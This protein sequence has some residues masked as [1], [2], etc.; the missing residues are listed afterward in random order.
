[1]NTP[2]PDSRSDSQHGPVDEDSTTQFGSGPSHVGR[3]Y[4]TSPAE[5]RPPLPPRPNTLDLLNDEAALRSTLQAGPTTA[6][7]RADIDTQLTEGVEST[8]LVFAG[9]GISRDLKA[10]ASLNQLASRRSSE[11]GD[12]ASIRSSI[13]K[14]DVGDIEALFKD[15]LAASPEDHT[16]AAGLLHFPEFPADGADDDQ[17]LSEFDPIGEL[18]EEGGNEGGRPY[19]KCTYLRNLIA[20]L[21]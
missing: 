12:T 14:G 17:F 16:N 15:F 8:H 7:S 13:R 18:D 11:T 2:Q 4:S 21:Y 20:D 10:K 3:K 9:P 6:V 5:Q 1:M 19:Q